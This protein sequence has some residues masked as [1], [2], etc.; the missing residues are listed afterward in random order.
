MSATAPPTP[1]QPMAPVR[2]DDTAARDARATRLTILVAAVVIVAVTVSDLVIGDRPVMIGL[3]AVAP[4]VTIPRGDRRTTIAVAVIVIAITALSG[5]WNDNMGTSTYVVRLLS[6]SAVALVST[7]AVIVRLRSRAEVDRQRELY[8]TL[9]RAQSEAGEGMAL[10]DGTIVLYANQ[11]ASDIVGRPAG[12]LRSLGSYLEIVKESERERLGEWILSIVAG[13]DVT[14]TIETTILHRDGHEVDV[15]LAAQAVTGMKGSIPGIAPVVVVGRDITDRKNDERERAELLAAERTA[16]ASMEASHRRMSVLA[17]VGAALEGSLDVARTLPAVAD[18]I[19]EEIADSCTIEVD[20][21]GRPLPPITR[22]RPGQETAQSRVLSLPLHAGQDVVGTMAVGR[23]SLDEEDD[24]LVRELARRVALAV[25]NARLYTERDHVART[26]QRSLLPP[27]LPE[28]RGY[29]LGAAFRPAGSGNE[30][31]GDFYD[32]FPLAPGQW[33]MVIGDVCGKGAD[34]AAVTALARYSLR[35]IA[36]YEQ[37]PSQVLG[38]LNDMLLRHATSERFCTAVFARIHEGPQGLVALSSGGHPS[39][40]KIRGGLVSEVADLTG[41]LLG[42]VPAP[43]LR[44][45][46]LSLDRGDTLIFFT[47]GVTEAR[48]ADGRPVGTAGLLAAVEHVKHEGPQEIA[49]HLADLAQAGDGGQRDDI[50]VL[51]LCRSGE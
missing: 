27:A 44:D 19:V 1:K 16:R 47:D 6:V 41:T 3:L 14:A 24:Q 49:D 10:L 22:T 43:P 13:Q 34:A 23:R 4:I 40:V 50:A 9:L 37:R 30:V 33:A 18:V 26:L 20:I 32:V 11:A 25:T 21:P 7:W 36:A 12:E 48:D 8:E 46:E 28:L 29:A 15:E 45:R 35:T 51:V 42:V 31:G 17:R 2:P 39:P 38:Q 5:L